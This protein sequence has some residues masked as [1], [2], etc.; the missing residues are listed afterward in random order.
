MRHR[1]E[2]QGYRHKVQKRTGV[3]Q[4]KEKGYAHMLLEESIDMGCSESLNQEID[5]V[6][7]SDFTF[8]PETTSLLKRGLGVCPVAS[9]DWYT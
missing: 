9:Y 7:L 1:N 4:Q 2:T 3:P 6:T 8:T 5:V